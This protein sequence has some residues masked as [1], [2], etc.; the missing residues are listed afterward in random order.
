MLTG[1][2]KF[3]PSFKINHPDYMGRTV[4]NIFDN[5]TEWCANILYTDDD[6]RNDNLRKSIRITATERYEDYIKTHHIDEPDYSKPF[7]IKS[8]R[9]NEQVTQDITEAFNRNYDHFIG[10]YNTPP[11]YKSKYVNYYQ[12]CCWIS[13]LYK[14]RK[15][16]R[17][18]Y[19]KSQPGES[20]QENSQDRSQGRTQE[21]TQ[22]RTRE[23]SQSRTRERSQERIQERTQDVQSKNG[24]RKYERNPNVLNPV[25]T[26]VL[27][28]F[29]N[30]KTIEE[31]SSTLKMKVIAVENI[32]AKCIALEKLTF[33]DV[34][35]NSD[36]YNKIIDIIEENSG[37]QS[38][39]EIKKKSEPLTPTSQE[40]RI[41]SEYIKASKRINKI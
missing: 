18:R 5:N 25:E 31:I 34:K 4:G 39:E 24:T 13:R 30:N 20:T 1:D 32:I 38:V 7:P 12:T 37:Y 19:Q 26:N 41:T 3:G 28:L 8:W 17:R 15:E 10:L 21:R 14:E 16:S 27:D 40:I 11:L 29:S 9:N 23:R 36:I 2:I 22:G 6:Y 35:I 33:E